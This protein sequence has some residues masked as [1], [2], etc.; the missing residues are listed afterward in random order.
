MIDPLL[1]T[2]PCGVLVLSETGHLIA[3]NQTLLDLLG[4]AR[5]ELV[6]TE[7]DLL[8]PVASRIFYRTH[9][10]P[11]LRLHGRVDEVYLT[12][13]P[14]GRADL[15]VLLNAVRRERDGV[16]V[17]EGIVVPMRQRHH[18]EDE[19]LQAR[20]AAEAATQAKDEFL[21]V[22]SH[23]LRTPLT[24]ILAWARMLKGGKLKESAAT[25]AVEIIERSAVTQAQLIEDLLDFSRIASGRLRLTMGP[26]D[27]REVAE[28]ALD[29]VRLTAQAKG[30]VL[31]TD[32]ALSV[33]PITGDPER[34]QQ[35]LWNVLSNAVKF[36]PPDGQVTMSLRQTEQTVEVTV[37][38]TGQGIDTA[39]LPYVFDRFRQA[40]PTDTRI[41][42]GVGLGMAI[43]RHLMELHGGTVQAESAGTGH[44]TTFT[45]RW[46]LPIDPPASLRPSR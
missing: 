40:D 31:V 22:V 42:S 35:V 37:Q 23:E 13:R 44:G 36:T 41:H 38:D 8:L 21:A 12:L 43:T 15:P 16:P 20:R 5:D 39:F 33:P 7:I 29:I 45:L 17:Y 27:L 24:A 30:V 18:Y 6:G 25:R 2:V 4:Y 1:D 26:V 28:H 19:I 9:L 10:V 3:V 34:L 14:R 32:L 11:M 46:P